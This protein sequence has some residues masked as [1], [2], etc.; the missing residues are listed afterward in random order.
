MTWHTTKE[1][2]REY[3]RKYRAEHRDKIRESQKKY[4]YAHHDNNKDR[5]RTQSKKYRASHREKIAEINKIWRKNNHEYDIERQRK[6][7][8]D[9]REHAI[10]YSRIYRLINPEKCKETNK[11]YRKN[12]PDKV[13]YWTRLYRKRKLST[14]GRGIT[15]K[16]ERELF[17]EYNY[18]CVY[19]GCKDKPLEIDHIVPI[20]SGGIDDIENATVACHSCNAS[21]QD[22]TLLRF[23]YDRHKYINLTEEAWSDK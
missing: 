4:Y 21:K 22:K 19:C 6:W 3:Y 9:N 17:K 13:R 2:Q 15:A 1:E 12:N 23:L 7:H 5:G 18:Q 10:E 20:I 16:Q 8:E 11:L 14:S